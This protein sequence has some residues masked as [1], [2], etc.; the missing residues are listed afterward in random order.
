MSYM[1]RLLLLLS[2]FLAGIFGIKAQGFPTISTD[3]VT[4]WYLIQFMNGG[5][6]LTAET[7]GAQITTSSAVG[8]DA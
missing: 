2:C 6:A 4:K 5:N 1:K 7:S 8:N 3:E